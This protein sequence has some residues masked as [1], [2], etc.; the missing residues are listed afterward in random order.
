MF[1]VGWRVARGDYHWPVSVSKVFTARLSACPVFDEDGDRIGKVRD[2]IVEYRAAHSPRVNG[3]V[4]ET[5]SKRLIF[6]PIRQVE[7]IGSGQIVVSG[8]IDS[9]PFVQ[10]GQEVRVLADLAD[11]AVTFNDGTASGTIEDV[12]IE[13]DAQ[14]NWS[15]GQLFVRLPRKS[16]QL[17][18]TGPT[19]FAPWGEVTPE[20]TIGEQQA[21]TQFLTAHSDMKPSDFATALLDLPDARLKE[22]VSMLPDERLADVL[23]EMRESDQVTIIE[24]LDEEHA[25]DVLDRMQP[26]DAADLVAKL[27]AVKSEALLQ[28]MDPEE[29]EEVR[30]LLEFAPDTAGGL[31]TTDP[32]ILPGDATVAEALVLIRR[33]DLP[34]ALATSVFVTLSPYEPPTG[35]YL[36]LVHFQRLLRYPPHERLDTILDREMEPAPT[37]MRD[38]EVARVLASYDLVAL[39]VIDD[40]HR[41]VGV[42]TIDD[43]LDHLL[44]ED[45]RQVDAEGEVVPSRVSQRVGTKRV[46]TAP[47]NSPAARRTHGTS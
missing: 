28:R 12:Q 17:F 13:E 9:R 24:W 35:R 27:D 2:V 46:V 21:A 32:V 14:G 15:V 34:A 1:A 31:M 23:E 5:K 40:A 18:G 33:K 3:L 10:H 45:W 16:K 6:I 26:D 22:V 8:E 25:A 4:V 30:M 44:P 36:G 47:A 37:T 19:R 39:P 7:S 29:A 41:L 20:L 43:V 11:R 38:A 42:V